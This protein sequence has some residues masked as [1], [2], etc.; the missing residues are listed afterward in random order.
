MNIAFC[1]ESVVPARGGC[2]TYIADLARRLTA[3]RH[4]VHIYASNWDAAALPPAIVYHALPILGGPRFLRPW[5][6]GSLCAAAL[7]ENAHDVTVGFDKTWGQD[8]LYP[9]GGLHLASNEGNLRKFRWEFARMAARGIK[10]FDLASWS[11]CRL[12]RR[13]YLRDPRP[14]VVVNSQ[15]VRDH[16]R[17][18]Y[19]EVPT[20]EVHVVRSAIDPSRFPEHDRPRC[21]VDF[22]KEWNIPVGA[23]VGLFAAMNYRLKG[24]DPLLHALRQ[25]LSQPEFARAAPVFHLI[26]AGNPNANSY[27]RLAH[28][29]GVEKHVVFVGHRTDMRSCYFAADFFVHPTF[30]DTCS[31]VVLE[32]LACGLPVITTRYGGVS[33]LLGEAREGHVIDDPHDRDKLAWCL[34]QMFDMGRRSAY[35]EAARRT[36]AQWTF[37]HHYREMLGVFAE[38][39]ACKE[40][41]ATEAA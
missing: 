10:L 21:R 20:E 36:A 12:E 29:L 39:M 40:S 24:L 25:L 26:V 35:A 34:K 14:V 18:Y 38:A 5:R 15:L 16:F 2:E 22:R 32:A 9:Q 27:R 28:R 30:Y 23:L 37:E 13:Q 6:F 3:D 4:D 33:E 11:Y 17:S 41:L 31:L 1:Y 19:P 7:K 8:I